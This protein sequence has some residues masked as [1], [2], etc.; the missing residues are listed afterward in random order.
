MLHDGYKNIIPVLDNKEEF[1]LYDDEVEMDT[2]CN[3]GIRIAAEE[4]PDSQFYTSR[5]GVRMEDVIDFYNNKISANP[6]F[7]VK[8]LHFF[9][10]SGIT[11]SPYYWNE[12]EK[13]VTFIASSKRSILNLIHLIL[14]VECHLKIVWYSI[15]ITNTWLMKS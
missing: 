11:D 4:Q 5:L 14:V 15:S 3:L 8:L 13:Y 6:N 7:R 2:P 9:I 12:L 10:N 1:N